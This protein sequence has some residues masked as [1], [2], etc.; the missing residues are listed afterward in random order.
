MMLSRCCPQSQLKHIHQL[1]NSNKRT[2]MKLIYNS[3]KINSSATHCV[4]FSGLNCQ[5]MPAEVQSS[6]MNWINVS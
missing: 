6:L 1:V 4:F 5:E 3:F 2:S